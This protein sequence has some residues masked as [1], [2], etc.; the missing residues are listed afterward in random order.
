M[1]RAGGRRVVAS[2]AIVP[3]VESGQT[4]LGELM[5]GAFGAPPVRIDT[6]FPEHQFALNVGEDLQAGG[7][8]SGRGASCRFD[9]GRRFFEGAE[10]LGSALLAWRVV[11][12][13]LQEARS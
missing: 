10:A 12:W 4:S 9:R 1:I 5:P 8:A 13:I 11:D 2:A 3:M 7:L 6:A